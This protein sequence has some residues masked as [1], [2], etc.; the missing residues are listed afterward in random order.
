M[1]FEQGQETPPHDQISSTPKMEIQIKIVHKDVK[2][3]FDDDKYE[4]YDEW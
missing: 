2:L 4:D 3:K 1:F